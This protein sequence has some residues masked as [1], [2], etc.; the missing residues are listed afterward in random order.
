M[1]RRRFLCEVMP[2]LSG[3]LPTWMPRL[4]FA[5]A[6]QGPRGDILIC[7]FLRGAADVLNMVVP[8]GEVAYYH[9]RPTL[10]I[11]RPDDQ[12]SPLPQRSID[13]DGFF[14]LHPALAPLLPAWQQQQLAI[15]HA[16]GAPDES[17]S[18][19]QAMELMERGVSNS[20]GPVSGWIGRH[21]DLLDTGN[22]SPLRALGVGERVQRALT[23]P[24]PATALR[25]IA[26]FHLG[27]DQHAS[28]LLAEQLAA[29]YANDAQLASQA[30]G[31]LE[32]L[33]LLEKLDPRKQLNISSFTYPDTEFSMGLRQLATLINNEVGLEVGCLDLGGWD[34]H[35]AQGGAEGWM[36]SLLGEL[37][38]GLQAFI[39]ELGERMQQVSIVVMSEFGRRV[40]ENGGLG[41]DHGH[42]SMMLLLGGGIAG[43]HVYGRWPGLQPEQLVGPGDLAITTDYRDVLSELLAKRLNNHMSDQIFPGYTP[44]WLGF[45]RRE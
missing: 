25:S 7:I 26:D 36:A 35:I 2:A 16:C 3:L 45:T 27:G 12:R 32:V 43:G 34:T 18:H 10:A 8:H 29:M 39:S 1:D 19:F 41:T 22:H 11:A 5:P 14:G 30:K 13:L 44:R 42:G 37:S 38:S 31:T 6:Q 33:T 23:G 28:R 4:S 9:S 20:S 15:I 21:L 24:I 17:R 40:G